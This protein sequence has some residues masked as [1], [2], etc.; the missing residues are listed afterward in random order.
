MWKKLKI[1]AKTLAQRLFITINLYDEN[2]LANHA[3]AGAYGFLLSVAPMLLLIAF[4]ILTAF[5]SVPNAIT[6]VFSNLPFLDVIIDE[7]WLTGNFL[8]VTSPGVSGIISVLSIFWAGRILAV[9]MQRGLKIIFTGIKTRNIVKDTLV[10][11]IVEIAV[12]FFVLIIVFGS[13][14]ALF[15]YRVFNFL[16]KLPVKYFLMSN[17]GRQIFPVLTLWLISFFAYLFM[18]ANSPRK[19]S[20]LLGAFFCVLGYEC[21][22]FMLGIILTQVKYN[23]LYGALGNLIFMLVNVYFFFVFFFMGAQFAFVVNSFDVLLFIRLR[24]SR[25]KVMEKL[26]LAKTGKVGFINRFFF[27]VEGKLKKYF[28]TYKEGEIIFSQ[29]DTAK[30]IF[31]LLDGKVELHFAHSNNSGISCIYNEC[32]FFGETGYLLSENRSATAKAKTGVSVLALP[33]GMFDEILKY[34][35]SLD[36][37][38]IE[39]MSRRLKNNGV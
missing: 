35:S 37:T 22:N 11:F 38:L 4:F 27:S 24:Q 15:F 6:S 13:Q 3:A 9:S 34:D 20:A 29:G 1:A 33:P 32:S 18:P 26:L 8:T 5:K 7:Q 28:R 30:D 23:L 25:D 31:Y 14:P 39:N 2:G 19:Y 21:I 10:T 16:P 36:R 12:L 17:I